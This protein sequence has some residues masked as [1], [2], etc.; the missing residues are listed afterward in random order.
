MKAGLPFVVRG[1][2]RKI[3]SPANA[4]PLRRSPLVS[5][6]SNTSS[7]TMTSEVPAKAIPTHHRDRSSADAG[8]ASAFVMARLDQAS[9]GAGGKFANGRFRTRLCPSEIRVWSLR[10][11]PA[12]EPDDSCALSG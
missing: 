10:G 3:R 4:R 1:R 8:S 7:R 5:A 11:E 12:L 2:T 9:P 6:I